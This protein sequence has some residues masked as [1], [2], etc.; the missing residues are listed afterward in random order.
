[1]QT[2]MPQKSIP[3]HTAFCMEKGNYKEFCGQHEYWKQFYMLLFPAVGYEN[4]GDGTREE[5]SIRVVSSFMFLLGHKNKEKWV[6]P[7][8]QRRD[9]SDETNKQKKPECR[10]LYFLRTRETYIPAALARSASCWRSNLLMPWLYELPSLCFLVLPVR[11]WVQFFLLQKK[12]RKMPF[13]YCYILNPSFTVPE[14]LAGDL[15]QKNKWQKWLA[16]LW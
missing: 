9:G 8:W 4:Y 6:I 5:T 10:I 2:S 12:A 11:C 14:L 1:M 15:V 16:V 13:F 3:R 7:V